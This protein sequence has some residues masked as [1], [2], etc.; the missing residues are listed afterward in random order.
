MLERLRCHANGFGEALLG[1][2][3]TL[4][5]VSR[6]L[7]AKRL[8]IGNTGFEWSHLN[9]RAS[10]FSNFLL[11][12]FEYQEIVR[13]RRANYL[14][15]ADQFD[16]KATALF[17]SLDAGVCPLFFPILVRDKH[18]AALRLWERGIGAVEFWNE[19]DPESAG[20][21][22]AHSHYLRKHVLELPIHQDVSSAQLEHI[23][24]EALQLELL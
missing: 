2:K 12:Q 15:L 21:Q 13:R 24:R 10:A 20:D 19:G 6:G 16:G 8:P 14:Y 4:G 1:L 7:G 9:I 3:R 11:Q 23:A 22:F 17:P 5:G 18:A